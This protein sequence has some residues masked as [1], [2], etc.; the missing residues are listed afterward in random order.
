[1]IAPACCQEVFPPGRI[2]PYTPK[3]ATTRQPSSVPITAPITNR[4]VG[5]D[6]SSGRPRISAEIS[7]PTTKK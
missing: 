3:P 5:V 4:R 1:M 6:G 7:L 2:R